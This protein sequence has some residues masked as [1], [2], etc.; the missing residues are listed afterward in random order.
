MIQGHCGPLTG[1]QLFNKINCNFTQFG[2]DQVVAPPVRPGFPDLAAL[3]LF[4]RTGADL[5]GGR[6]QS[7]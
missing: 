4:S 6:E 1:Y 2:Q 5:G 3:A 7:D